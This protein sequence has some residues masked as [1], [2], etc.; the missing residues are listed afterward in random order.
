ML[1]IGQD[2]RKL[3]LFL[4]PIPA[5]HVKHLGHRTPAD[6]FDERGFFLVRGRTFLGIQ[7]PDFDALRFAETS[8]WSAVTE[9]VGFR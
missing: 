7:R 5:V 2:F 8:A 3:D 6:V 4:A 1:V 9:P